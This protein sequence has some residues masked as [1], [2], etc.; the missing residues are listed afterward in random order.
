M[1]LKAFGGVQSG[2]CLVPISQAADKPRYLHTGSRQRRTEE[3]EGPVL[4]AIEGKLGPVRHAGHLNHC[5]IWQLVSY[6]RHSH[7]LITLVIP[8]SPLVQPLGC[9]SHVDVS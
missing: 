4:V 8:A 5:L 6:S 7:F 3:G 2:Q 1:S 9:Y